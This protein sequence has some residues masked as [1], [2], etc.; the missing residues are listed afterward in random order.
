MYTLNRL[1]GHKAVSLII[2]L[3]KTGVLHKLEQYLVLPKLFVSIV[4]LYVGPQEPAL[5]QTVPRF[6]IMEQNV[7]VPVFNTKFY[8]SLATGTLWKKRE[9]AG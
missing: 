7:L 3:N 1:S 5:A 4:V 6:S 9:R 2:F 8:T